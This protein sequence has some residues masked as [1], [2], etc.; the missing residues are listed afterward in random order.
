M[1]AM[2]DSGVEWIG[3]IPEEWN[4]MPLGRWLTTRDGGAWGDQEIGDDNDVVCLRIADFDYP[5]LTI[6]KTDCY[7]VRN[8]NKSIIERLQL[9]YGDILVEKSG[10]GEKT[11]VGRAVMYTEGFCSLFTNF[12]DRLRV[13]EEFS[14]RYFLYVW[15]TLYICDHVS[16]FI[17]QTTGIQNLDI[18]TMLATTMAPLPCFLEQTRIA[19]FLDTKCAQIDAII[20]KQQQVIEKLKA[21]K[22]SVIT[23][24]VTKGLDPAVPMKDSGVEWIGMVPEHWHIPKLMY[25][26][27]I[28]SG[29]TPDRNHPEYWD[30][31]IYW[32]KTGELLNQEIWSA[33]EKITELGLMNS[34]AKVFPEDTLLVA[35]YGQGKTRGMTALLKVPATTNQACAGIRVIDKS[36]SVHYL[37]MFFICAYDAI[38]EIAAGSGQPNL[39]STLINNFRITVPSIHEQD[40]ILNYINHRCSKIDEIISMKTTTI[41]KLGSYKKSIIYEAV[42]GKMEV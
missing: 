36:V 24:A 37:W 23:E 5:K 41:S 15:T 42:T 31:N 1:R 13:S 12:M 16:P 32:I 27:S 9:H 8:Y 39:S 11:P 35:M 22:Q 29:G 18:R 26:A 14:N 20:E 2:K 6:K 28:S 33:E 38:R 30:G 4:Q 34:S 19:S 25:V 3:E 21:Y 7:T 17:K 40:R 10:G